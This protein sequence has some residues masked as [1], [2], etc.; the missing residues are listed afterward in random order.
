MTNICPIILPIWSPGSKNQHPIIEWILY[1]LKE[2]AAYKNR[3]LP[4]SR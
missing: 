4:K 3:I 1:L 2:T